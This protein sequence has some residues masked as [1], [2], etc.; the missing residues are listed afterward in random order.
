M[1]MC[2]FWK[3]EWKN[4]DKPSPK[5]V[6]YGGF[7]CYWDMGGGHIL[8]YGGRK[9]EGKWGTMGKTEGKWG[10]MGENGQE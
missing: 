6:E 4:G 2:H 10:K 3:T 9:N 7:Q 1:K 8:G 5:K